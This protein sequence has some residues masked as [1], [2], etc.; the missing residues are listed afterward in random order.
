[1][2]SN[3]I[4]YVNIV[5]ELVIL[6][7]GHIHYADVLGA[8]HLEAASRRKLITDFLETQG[9]YEL[10]ADGYYVREGGVVV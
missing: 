4:S 10:K 2:F 9:D 5:K 7:D 1:M 8:E 3:E 6:I